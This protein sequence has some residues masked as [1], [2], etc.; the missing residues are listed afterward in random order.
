LPIFLNEIPS[1]YPQC[2][3]SVELHQYK[4]SSHT[5]NSTV[6][7]L[8]EMEQK[9]GIKTIPF[10]DIPT[11]PPD[12]SPMEF[13]C[14]RTFKICIIQTSSHNL[15]GL[16]KVVLEEWDRIP[17]LT[18]QTALLSWKLR[19]RKIVQNTGYQIEH[20]KHKNFT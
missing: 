13:L 18:L 20:V 12:A 6:N 14:F 9:T 15:T 1:L 16:W 7:F 3:Q 17:L 4:A 2:H 5:S 11:K 19:C 8:K 10:T